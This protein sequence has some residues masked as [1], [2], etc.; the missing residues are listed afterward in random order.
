MDIYQKFFFNKLQEKL[1]N[2]LNEFLIKEERNGK[3]EYKTKI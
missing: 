3:K 2:I 1:Y